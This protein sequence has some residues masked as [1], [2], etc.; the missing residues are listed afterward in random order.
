MENNQQVVNNAR[1]TGCGAE[2][3]AQPT[4]QKVICPSCGKEDGG[5]EFYLDFFVFLL[6]FSANI[7][8][9]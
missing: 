9:Q 6:Y 5:G 4:E 3:F 7:C 1:C 2:F 8:F